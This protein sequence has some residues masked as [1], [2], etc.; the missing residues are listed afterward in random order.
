MGCVEH[1]LRLLS[2][3][4]RLAQLGSGLISFFLRLGLECFA[5]ANEPL[6][7]VLRLGPRLVEH[8]L[9]FGVGC[10]QYFTRPFLGLGPHPRKIIFLFLLLRTLTAQGFLHGVK[11]LH[12]GFALTHE[13]STPFFAQ[14]I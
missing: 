5:V 14:L 2:Q 7:R 3:R 8:P 1:G 6:L 12:G 10:P 9:A 13:D 4:L 11:L